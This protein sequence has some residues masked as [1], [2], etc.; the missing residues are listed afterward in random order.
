[1]VV[2]SLVELLKYQ[3][4]NLL[5]NYFRNLQFII[6]KLNKSKYW[7]L[8]N[9]NRD[10]VCMENYISLETW[11]SNEKVMKLF[12]KNQ[13]DFTSKSGFNNKNLGSL[14]TSCHWTGTTSISP[15]THLHKILIIST[16]NIS[17]LYFNFIPELKPPSV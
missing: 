17:Y 11:K 16:K 10:Q 12:C 9:C 8:T 1:M 2:G 13:L 4:I 14:T 3:T 15:I 6:N 5:E 7:I